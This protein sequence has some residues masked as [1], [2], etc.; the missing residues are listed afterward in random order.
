MER[1]LEVEMTNHLGYMRHAIEGNNTG[2]S[3][4]GKTKKPVKTGNGDIQIEVPRDRE[5]EF[6]PEKK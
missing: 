1:L 2:N 3:C 6:E 4:N 5:S